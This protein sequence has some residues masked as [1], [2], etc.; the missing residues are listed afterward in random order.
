MSQVATETRDAYVALALEDLYLR[1]RLRNWAAAYTVCAWRGL[2]RGGAQVLLRA[3]KGG[4]D[5][6]DWAEDSN[7]FVVFALKASLFAYL[8]NS[9]SPCLNEVRG[10]LTTHVDTLLGYPDCCWGWCGPGVL[11]DLVR[12]SF[13]AMVAGP[14]FHLLPKTAW[15]RHCEAVLM[16][17]SARLGA[18]A[19]IGCLD[20]G[21]LCAILRLVV[22]PEASCAS[23]TLE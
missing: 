2:A 12:S 10:M 11:R 4:T 7:D 22:A 13:L 15:P 20:D 3:V 17:R 23:V 9:H 5:A 16:A 21:L 1:S 14:S 8:A 6:A 18:R 19:A